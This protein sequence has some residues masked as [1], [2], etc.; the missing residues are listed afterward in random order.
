MLLRG[1]LCRPC[2]AEK[3]KAYYWS[4]RDKELARAKGDPKRMKRFR[5]WRARIKAEALRRYS[6]GEPAC[7][8]CGY[9]DE[10]ALTLD[11]IN[12]D[13]AEHRR[14]EGFAHA[15]V[16]A[17]TN[18]WPAIFQVLCMNCQFIKD[19]ARRARSPTEPL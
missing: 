2:H 3:S 4:N 10:R 14:K 6:P 15:A 19:H 8:H 7:A 13:G 5:D 1:G 9:K 11:H 12:D 18:G 17:R 16:W